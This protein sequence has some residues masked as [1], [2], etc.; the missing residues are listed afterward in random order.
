M[1]REMIA[2]DHLPDY[3]LEEIPGDKLRVTP[4]GAM[5]LPLAPPPAVSEAA[6]EAARALVPGADVHGL[7]AE[8]QAVW[9]RTGQQRLRSPDKAFLGWVK[10]RAG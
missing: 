1:L 9:A 3:H 2:T 4:R 7:R 10:K 6:L 5:A 8:W